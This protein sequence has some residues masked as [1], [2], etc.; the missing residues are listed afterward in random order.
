MTEALD[1]PIFFVLIMTV[2]VFCTAAVIRWGLKA[3]N[4]GGGAAVFGG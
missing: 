3:G 2:A 4:F 1:H